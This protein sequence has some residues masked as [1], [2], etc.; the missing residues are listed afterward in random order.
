[1]SENEGAE[2]RLERAGVCVLD[3]CGDVLTITSPQRGKS[4][5]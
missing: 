4:P 5:R 3:M 2:V 1:M